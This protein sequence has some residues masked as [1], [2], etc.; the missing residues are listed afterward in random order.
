[1]ENACQLPLSNLNNVL[2][3]DFI[4]VSG[5]SIECAKGAISIAKITGSKGATEIHRKV[6]PYPKFKNLG[7]QEFAIVKRK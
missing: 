2:I 1:M 4:V 6:G 7:I 5:N 3:E